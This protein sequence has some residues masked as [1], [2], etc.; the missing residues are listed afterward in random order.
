M[1]LFFF[2]I[3]YLY[4]IDNFLILIYLLS[5]LT[6]E[7]AYKLSL[8]FINKKNSKV[9]LLLNFF[10]VICL[11]KVD[12]NFNELLIILSSINFF[13]VLYLVGNLK[14]KFKFNLFTLSKEL[15]SYKIFIKPQL[16]L[17]ILILLNDQI[18]FLKAYDYL[19]VQQASCIRAFL[20]LTYVLNIISLSFENLVP[21]II[22]EIDSLS[23]KK[24]L[25]YSVGYLGILLVGF[26]FLEFLSDTI[27][28]ILL[29]KEYL[30]F[31]SYLKYFFSYSYFLMGYQL[32]HSIIKFGGHSI[33]LIPIHLINFI[34]L[35]FIGTN[36][37]KI[38]QI[39]GYIFTINIFSLSLLIISF[40]TVLKLKVRGN[41]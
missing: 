27:I 31:S 5:I 17:I 11:I 8:L 15:I 41:Y 20:T 19:D 39:N 6:L 30:E 4:N 32:L 36:L 16:I 23:L 24:I 26:I 40:I 2:I 9:F 34:F 12:Y 10:I 25:K 35:Y 22:S 38:N 18:F 33:K 7:Y 37:V 3:K 13:G 21:M 14:R 28:I 29:K 1:V